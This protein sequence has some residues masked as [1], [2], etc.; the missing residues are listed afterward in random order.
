MSAGEGSYVAKSVLS[1]QKWSKVNTQRLV[2]SRIFQVL[3]KSLG[4]YRH[5]NQ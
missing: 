5:P 1:A 3:S 2:A 4:W